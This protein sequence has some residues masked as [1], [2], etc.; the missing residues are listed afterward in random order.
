[1][2]G[3]HNALSLCGGIDITTGCLLRAFLRIEIVLMGSALP[4]LFTTWTLCRSPCAVAGDVADPPAT[5]STAI[6]TAIDTIRSRL[7]PA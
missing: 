2:T 1:M 4:P 7:C 6:A 3:A 5:T